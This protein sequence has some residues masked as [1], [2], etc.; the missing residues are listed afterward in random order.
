MNQYARAMGMT[1]TTFKNANGLTRDGHMSTARDMATLGR[2]LVYD[3][4][5]YYNIFSRN[6]TS[7]G[8]ATVRNTNR[9]LLD[10]YPGADGIKTGYTRASGFSLVSSAA[11]GNQRVIV[12]MMG[13]KSSASRNAE[14]ARL[15][16][17]GF[18]KMPRI[19][20]LDA[21][22]PL[23]VAGSATTAARG[24]TSIV[25]ASS[26]LAFAGRPRPRA[27]ADGSI[28]V[29]RNNQ[30]ITAAIAEVNAELAAAQTSRDLPG[31]RRPNGR[32][33]PRP[34][35]GETAPAAV[36]SASTFAVAERA[37]RPADPDLESVQVA[38]S[39]AGTT[40]GNEWGVQL[41]AFRSKGDAE[42]QL[43]TTALRDVPELAG[44]LRRVEA[45][46]VQGVTI[47]RAQFVGLDQAE[48]LGACEA[49]ARAQ[50]ACLPLAPGI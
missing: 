15:M 38:S 28:S 37:P 8:I 33:A 6:S 11:R 24:S 19:A 23:A 27:L 20:S 3:F 14:V 18:A 42:R 49:L 17:L 46:K 12:S 10:A 36:G 25:A 31:V 26:A 9:R 4:P 1:R 29:A 21:P 30:S 2:R 39:G 40:G 41:G 22:A 44:G 47:Y 50:A 34:G 48:A 13:G 7:A 32:P 43:L 35:A 16:D 45:A 5:Q